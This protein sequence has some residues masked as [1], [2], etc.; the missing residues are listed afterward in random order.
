MGTRT[1]PAL[2]AGTLALEVAASPTKG[3]SVLEHEWRAEPLFA[4]DAAPRLLT[5]A[6][7]GEICE[8]RVVVDQVCWC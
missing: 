3:R 2:R 5:E 6:E 8:C 1:C 7:V 4:D